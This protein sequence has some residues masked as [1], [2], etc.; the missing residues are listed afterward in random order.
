MRKLDELETN[1]SVLSNIL[2]HMLGAV[3]QTIT[4][5]LRKRFANS[6]AYVEF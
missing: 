1:S 6:E 4:I 2:V 5:L 3:V